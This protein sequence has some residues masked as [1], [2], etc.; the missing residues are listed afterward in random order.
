MSRAIDDI[1]AERRRQIKEEGWTAEH[2]D[3]HDEGELSRAGAC[4]VRYAQT[5]DAHRAALRY[6]AAGRAPADW[7]FEPEWFKPPHDRRRQLVI[8][9]AMIA[10]DIDRLD[11]KNART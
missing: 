7:P 5:E 10:A 11:R 3:G 2:D 9:T 8:G 4:Y 1:A 6:R